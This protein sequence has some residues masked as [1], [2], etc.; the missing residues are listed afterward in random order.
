MRPH[1]TWARIAVPCIAAGLALLSAPAYAEETP[2]PLPSGTASPAPSQSGEPHTRPEP[3]TPTRATT[4]LAVRIAT[5]KVAVDSTGKVMRVDVLNNGPD[6]ATDVTLTLDLSQLGD[7]VE[8]GV[9]E[10]AAC[11]RSGKTITCGYAE[12]KA[13]ATRITAFKIKPKG[14]AEPGPAG[15]AKASVEAKQQS[16]PDTDNNADT[17]AIQIVDSAVDLVA[18][19]D[20]VGPVKPGQSAQLKWAFGNFG[21][22]AAKGITLKFSLPAY[23]T[24]AESYS[25]CT[26]SKNR[27]ELVCTA[28]NVVLQPGEIILWNSPGVRPLH[29]KVAGDAPGPI[30]L[31][32]GEFVSAALG[33]VEPQPVEGSGATMMAA[34]SGTRSAPEVD[35]DDNSATFGV[36]TKANPTELAV[37]VPAASGQ[38]GDTVKVTVTVKNN[39]PADA[40][41]FLAT[42]ALPSGTTLAQVPRACSYDKAATTLTCHTGN[43]L[44]SGK[45]AKQDL[46]LT[47]TS[48]NL[49]N[50]WVRIATHKIPDRV[51]GNN[52]AEI[53]VSIGTGGGGGGLPVTGASLT[54][55]IG[56]GTAAVLLGV[57]LYAL[58]RRRRTTES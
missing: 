53:A 20:D 30:S 18:A 39:G 13:G 8:L 35:G 9:H 41:G 4:D 43:M 12:I 40:N 31:G 26:T 51:P 38:V 44:D 15:T 37:S 33:E 54:G 45:T 34:D 24:F 1:R 16:D 6:A 42:I 32:R 10:D 58:A 57:V 21:D 22:T 47:I 36:L 49:D 14:G 48:K 25:D 2:S 11:E 46:L 56:G 52:M 50:G 28:E 55:V 5:D 19:A 7:N 27:R 3:T 23:A 17:V 29:V